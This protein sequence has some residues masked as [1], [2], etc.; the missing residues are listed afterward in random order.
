MASSSKVAEE[1]LSQAQA[2]RSEEGCSMR[3]TIRAVARRARR[4]DTPWRSRVSPNCSSCRAFKAIRS[5]PTLRTWGVIQGVEMHAGAIIAGFGW[6]ALGESA[7]ELQGELMQFRIGVV[8]RL[9][10]EPQVLEDGQQGGP[11]VLWHGEVGA[12]VEQGLL[13]HAAG[14]APAVHQA[15][16]V[17]GTAR[18]AGAGLGAANEDPPSVAVGGRARNPETSLTTRL[19][20]YHSLCGLGWEGRHRLDA[21]VYA[22][23]TAASDRKNPDLRPFHRQNGEVGMGDTKGGPFDVAGDQACEWLRLPA[24][25]NG[26]TNADILKPWVNGMGPHAAAGGQVDRRL[27]VDDVSRRCSPVRGAVPVG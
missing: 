23:R 3:A 17:I 9:A 5:A 1:V 11:L 6:G 2:A 10:L 26:R 21:T 14:G 4:G 8:E 27:R 25:P 13:A 20:H 15:E 16:G 19:W 18:F 7:V 24:N 22:N 12:E